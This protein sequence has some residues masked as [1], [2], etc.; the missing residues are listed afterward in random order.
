M[1]NN[2]LQE[3]TANG[4]SEQKANEIINCLDRKEPIIFATTY[5]DTG[6]GRRVHQLLTA[7]I[8]RRSASGH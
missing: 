5:L 8:A 3:L 7:E 2:L 1:T 6:N 4:V